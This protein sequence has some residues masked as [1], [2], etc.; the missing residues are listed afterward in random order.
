MRATSDL[1]HKNNVQIGFV[2]F[3]LALSRVFN[4]VQSVMKNKQ[5]INIFTLGAKVL[6]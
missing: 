2:F 6:Q 1:R 4:D 5:N 3:V